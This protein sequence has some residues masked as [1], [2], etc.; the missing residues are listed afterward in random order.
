MCLCMILAPLLKPELKNM[1]AFK[2]A[3]V[4]HVA[5]KSSTFSGSIYLSNSLVITM[6][7]LSQTENLLNISP[8]VSV[9]SS[10]YCPGS[11]GATNGF[12]LA[13]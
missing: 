10:I 13:C 4:M 2:E 8:W 1:K 7:C 12:F 9:R 11:N 5:L 6:T 3:I